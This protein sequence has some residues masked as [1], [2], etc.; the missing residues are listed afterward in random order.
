MN[1]NKHLEFFDPINNINAPINI[2]GLGAI[3][4]NLA[5][6][7]TRLG[8]TELNIFDFDIVNPHNLTNQ[9]FRYKDIGMS[10][11][12]ALTEILLEINP[13]LKISKN[14][15]GYKAQNITGYIFLCVDNIDTRREIVTRTCMNPY[16]KAYFDFRIGLEEAQHY[17]SKQDAASIKNFLGSMTFTHAEAKEATPISACGTTLSINPT[18]QNIVSV[19]VANFINLI[20]TNNLKNMILINAFEFGISAF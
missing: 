7:L 17:A 1:L 18:V 9:A 20:K 13:A 11:V 2:I 12:D 10:K 6:A 4:S 16:V 15:D 14:P 5:V 8:V 19:G 3:G